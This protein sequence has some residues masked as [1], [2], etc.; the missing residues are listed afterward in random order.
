MSEYLNNYKLVL[1]KMDGAT[2]FFLPK[3]HKAKLIVVTKTF[4]ESEILPI[5][6]TGHKIYGENKVQ[7]AQKKWESLRKKFSIELHLIGPLQSNKVR[8]AL[9]TFDAIQ[10]IDREKIAK[11]ISYHL[12]NDEILNN[13]PFKFFVQINTGDEPQKSGHKLQNAKEFILWC[14]NDLKLKIYGLMCIPPVQENPEKHF[15][16]LSLLA[17]ETS[18]EHTSMG[19]TSDYLQAI[20]NG[21]S[22]VRVG[23]AIFGKRKLTDNN[24]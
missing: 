9:E 5:L 13:K 19:M 16:I 2:K 14:Q 21:A 1:K 20:K 23:S 11:K 15:K 10:T 8:V 22:Y 7:E 3:D 4:G 17:K 18:I 12:N 6:K 24:F